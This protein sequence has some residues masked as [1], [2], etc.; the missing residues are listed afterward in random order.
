MKVHVTYDIVTEESAEHG[1]AA[2]RGFVLPGGWHIELPDG[3]V[4]QE[5]GKVMDECAIDLREALNLISCVYDGGSGLYETDPRQ[6]YVTG[7]E[8]TRA[9]HLPDN[10]TPASYARVLRLLKA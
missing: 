5:A 4:G 7:A 10:I 6:D 2:E 9:L 3:V 1:D 8:E